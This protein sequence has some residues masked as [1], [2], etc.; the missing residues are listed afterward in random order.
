MSSLLNHTTLFLNY[1]NFIALGSIEQ[2]IGEFSHFVFLESLI[3]L[4]AAH[5][6]LSAACG[7]VCHFVEIVF[8]EVDRFW[9]AE[10]LSVIRVVQTMLIELVLIL[11]ARCRV[12]LFSLRKYRISAVWILGPLDSLF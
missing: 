6:A 12:N 9:S 2:D 8:E 10:N 5:A 3:L 7:G 11:C 4:S 1:M